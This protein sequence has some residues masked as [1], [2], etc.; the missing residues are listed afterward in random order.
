MRK[1]RGE[2]AFKSIFILTCF[3]LLYFEISLLFDEKVTIAYQ[4]EVL[5][6]IK[7]GRTLV[8]YNLDLSH[9]ITR[10]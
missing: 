1:G 6:K 2:I 9:D 4:K 5:K 3:C 7:R 10:G 8:S